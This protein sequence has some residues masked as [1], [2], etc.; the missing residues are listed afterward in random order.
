M[1]FLSEQEFPWNLMTVGCDKNWGEA[2]LYFVLFSTRV[3]IQL[4]CYTWMNSNLILV[5]CYVVWPPL[6]NVVQGSDPCHALRFP[7]YV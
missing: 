6:A 4:W 7:V 2:V 3:D 1:T 5:M